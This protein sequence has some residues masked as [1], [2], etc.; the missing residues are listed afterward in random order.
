MVRLCLDSHPDL[1][2]NMTDT[3]T[4]EQ[5]VAD[6]EGTN[7]AAPAEEAKAEKVVVDKS[8]PCLCQFYEVYDPKDVEAVFTTGC[9]ASTKA[10]FAQGHDARL[11]SFLVDGKGDGYEIRVVKDGKTTSYDTP[12]EAVA[13]VSNALQGKAEKAWDNKRAKTVAVAERKA[14]R[15]KLKAD[16]AAAKAKADEERAAAKAAKADGPKATGAEV[17]A[18]SAEGEQAELQPGQAVIKVGRWEYVANITGD[19]T[20][21]YT[22]GKGKEE[23]RERDGYQLLRAYEAPA[24]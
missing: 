11:V 13:D 16:K 1:E 12:A 7:E 18:G 21:I 20:A 4:Q 9:E 23:T 3:V 6:P 22:D 24:A 14:A 19:G 5:S 10:T 2:G 8:H 15:D 17:V